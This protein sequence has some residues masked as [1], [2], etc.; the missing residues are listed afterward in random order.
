MPI[1]MCAKE[2]LNLSHKI[3]AE[4][5]LERCFKPQFDGIAGAKVAHVIHVD[6]HIQGGVTRD[7]G[8]MKEA[9]CMC[10]REETKEGKEFRD[11]LIPMT[12]TP[13][14]T[15]KGLEETPI[16]TEGRNGTVLW[17]LHN[18]HF[19][20]RQSGLTK[21]I[22]GIALF[23]CAILLYGH[24]DNQPY[25]HMSSH[26]SMAVTFRPHGNLMVSQHHDADLDPFGIAR[27]VQLDT[28]NSHA[29]DGCPTLL[30]QGEVLGMRNNDKSV[31][32]EEALI[33]FMVCGKP[34]S[35]IN[36][37]GVQRLT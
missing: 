30:Q 9:G 27:R 4:V 24:G 2:Q 1:I 18:H 26:G 5:G 8:A 10:A 13:T 35:L 3:N 15:I 6:G 32:P 17:R 23:Q 37:R 31:L 22:L 7:R 14:E 19:S 28:E 11:E 29:R 33:F 21:R 12:G 34:E 16:G 20:W 25:L 36:K